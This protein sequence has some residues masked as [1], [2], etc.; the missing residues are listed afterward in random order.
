MTGKADTIVRAPA[1][2]EAA[3]EAEA[4]AA[5]AKDRRHEAAPAARRELPQRDASEVDDEDELHEIECCSIPGSG[6]W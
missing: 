1:I 5:E 6:A 4:E 3:A 2:Q